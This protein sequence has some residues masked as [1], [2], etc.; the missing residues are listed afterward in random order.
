MDWIALKHALLSHLPVAAGLL[1]PWPLI[2]AQRPGRGIR[3]WWTVSRYLGWMGL[4]GTLCAFVSG[5]ASGRF[6]GIIPAHRLLPLAVSGSGPEALLY[7][8]AALAAGSLILGIVAV[9]AMNRSRKDHQSLGFLT[10]LLGL[11]WS[12]ALL[13]AGEGG[14]RLAHGH[15]PVPVVA[16]AVEVKPVP[17][18]APPSLPRADVD[19]EAKI[20]VRALDY[21]ALEPIQPDPVKSPAHGGRWIRAWASPEAAAAYRAGQPLP[22]GAM[23]VLSSVED[24]W[25]RP[26]P[27]AGPLFA[28]EI[29]PSGPA[30][31]FYWA[32]IPMERRREFGGESRAY[33]RGDDIH[34]V[35]CRSCHATGMAD[36]AQRSRWRAKKVVPGE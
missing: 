22:Q 5:F 29:K 27:D 33:W 15:A 14:Y 30:L 9:W 17:A 3:P 10:L 23:V 1:L 7:R 18:P 11:A 28:L 13:L 26:G 12:A 8:H 19:T 31:S 36:P 35:S 4:L 25:G 20:P 6:L 24:R 2:A 16:P 34:L 21:A 32:R